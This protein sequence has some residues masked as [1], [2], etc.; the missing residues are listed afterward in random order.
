MILAFYCF[1]EESSFQCQEFYVR[2]QKVAS[3]YQMYQNYIEEAVKN[4]CC[5]QCNLEYLMIV[6]SNDDIEILNFLMIK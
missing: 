3:D 5:F 6:I 2:H 4:F 1:E